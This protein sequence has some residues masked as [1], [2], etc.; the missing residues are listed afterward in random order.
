MPPLAAL[1]LFLSAIAA[2]QTTSP[3]K[4]YQEVFYQSGTLRIQAYLYKPDGNGPFP[5]VIYNHG[6][7][8]GRERVSVPFVYIGNALTAGGYLVLV[9][10][11]R[12]YGASDGKTYAED[13]GTDRG[14]R[15]VDRMQEETGDVLAALEYLKALPLADRQRIAIMGWS[16]GGIVSVFA[17]GRSPVFRAVVDQAGGALAWDGSP[18]MQKA[19]KDAAAQV[20][21]PLLAMVA[22]NDR[23]IRSSEAVVQEM[24]KRHADA[25]LI[26]YPAYQPPQPVAPTP[27]GHA[28]F[29]ADGAPI[30]QSDVMQFLSRHLGATTTSK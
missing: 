21:A 17:A 24:Q 3:A 7:R 18:A 16:L 19:L 5:V 8:A 10:E 6:S 9:P 27:S 15:F 13:I 1:L 2:A 23:T 29:A 11:R 12:G 30:W 4:P 20:K 22:Q 25:R 26:V 28:I 14:S